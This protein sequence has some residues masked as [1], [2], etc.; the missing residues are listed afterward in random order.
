MKWSISIGYIKDGEGNGAASVIRTRDLTL[1]KG[2]LYRWSYGSIFL[3]SRPVQIKGQ[4]PSGV[5]AANA[6]Q[7]LTALP[8]NDK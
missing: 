2:A 5:Y 8:Q 6:L 3:K 1:T 7:V 4:G